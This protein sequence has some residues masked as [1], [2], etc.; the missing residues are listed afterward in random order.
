MALR[1]VQEWQLELEVRRSDTGHGVSPFE[2][3]PEQQLEG[4]SGVEAPVLPDVILDGDP[5]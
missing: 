1:K 5:K 2:A 4:V 3:W